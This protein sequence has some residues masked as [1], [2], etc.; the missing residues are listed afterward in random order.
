M[1]CDFEAAAAAI[2]VGD[3]AAEVLL[4]RSK[5]FARNSTRSTRLICLTFTTARNERVRF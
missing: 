2:S 1:R 5:R 4:T 3:A